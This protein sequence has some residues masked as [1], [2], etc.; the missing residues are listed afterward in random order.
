MNQKTK[1]FASD[2]RWG[3]LES[4]RPPQFDGYSTRS[5]YVPMPDGVRLALDI[6]LPLDLPRSTPLPALL[7]RTRYWRRTQMQDGSSKPNPFISFFTSQG[8]AV[9]QADVRGTGASFGHMRFE[10]QPEDTRD[11]AILVDWICKQEWSNGRVGAYGVSYPGTT[12]ELLAETC[13]PAL[14]AVW[15]SYF[16]LDGYT[17]LAF[18]GGVPCTFVKMWGEYTSA[19]DQNISL[20]DNFEPDPAV[21]GVQPVDGDED[22]QL[23]HLAIEEH[24]ENCNAHVFLRDVV[25][26][27]DLLGGAGVPNEEMAVY[28]RREKIESSGVAIDIWGSWLDANTA[29]TVLRHFATF[30]N[31]QRA[32][33]SAWS[34][35]GAFLCSPFVSPG[36]DP[37]LSRSEQM[38]EILRF[39]DQHFLGQDTQI[40]QKTLFYYTMGEEKWKA[41]SV[42]PPEGSTTRRFFFQPD[43]LLGDKLPSLSGQETY[44]VDYDAQTG[45]QNRWWTELGGGPV[46]YPDREEQDQKLLVYESSPL[47]ADLEITGYPVVDLFIASSREDGAFFVYLEAVDDL[48]NVTYLTEG[49]LRA[50]HRKVS[51]ETPPY[52]VFG[53]YHSYKRADG[54]LLTPGEVAELS[55]SLFPT[56]VRVSKGH[57]IRV[58]IAGADASSFDRVPEQGETEFRLLRGGEY[59]SC[60]DLPIIK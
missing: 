30:R 40:P 58:S 57:K 29:D 8:Y 3:A 18:P 60:I 22:H 21:V 33:I 16:E 52:Q 32:V 26:R 47:E 51:G 13:H 2:I 28:S 39:L 45:Q 43:H 31:P 14:R 34:H 23:L 36:S 10:W 35:G 53:P 46:I 50:L 37:E 55:F 41:T 19:L 59:P 38:N 20:D 42:W 4:H 17:D 25:Y 49:M 9:V 24:A 7:Y 15:A 27:D 44:P 11:A 54:K 56:S 6:H 1:Y 48:G 12:A 5:I